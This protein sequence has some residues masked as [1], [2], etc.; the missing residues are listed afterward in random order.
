LLFK[1]LDTMDKN[2]EWLQIDKSNFFNESFF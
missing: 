1:R 2:R